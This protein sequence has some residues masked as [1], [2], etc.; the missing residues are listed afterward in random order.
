MP[1]FSLILLV[2]SALFL[3]ACPA[4]SVPTPE[5]DITAFSA[6]PATI[7]AGEET[8]LRW[9]VT[10]EDLTLT[11]DNGVGTV[12]GTSLRVAPAE[13]TAYTLSATGS[14]GSDT[15]TITVAVNPKTE[16]PKITAFEATPAS[17]FAGEESVLSWTLTGSAATLSIDNGVGEVTGTSTTIFPIETTTYT[18]TASN[19]AGS[20][21]ATFSV[22]VE[23][24]P[25][26]ETTFASG[27]KEGWAVSSATLATFSEG[28]SGGGN[29]NGYIG[30]TLPTD[31]MTSYYVAPRKFRTNWLTYDQLSFDVFSSG[32]EYFTGESPNR[33]DV[34]LANG[35][36]TAQR[37]FANRPGTEW[38]SFVIP[39]SDD[40]GWLLGGGATSL[41]E[42]LRRVT[43][44]QI[45]AEYGMGTDS[46]GLD[47]V[48]L[49]SND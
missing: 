30:V 44:F 23:P 22:T 5:T 12:T 25:F 29:N 33:G 14:D 40:G 4:P 11:I 47:N 38:E 48:R 3:T 28:G 37:L 20:D 31:G 16:A 21:S 8:T 45:R 43:S 10:G 1:R 19:S 26:V 49:D 35:A 39:L 27:E 13:T 42:V 9:T 41:D 17:I 32:G 2:V 46:S 18:L 34:F 15:A 24:P 7:T 36:F 6:D